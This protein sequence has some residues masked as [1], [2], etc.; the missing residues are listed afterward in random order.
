MP[1]PVREVFARGVAIGKATTPNAG[2]RRAATR[3]T[4]VTVRSLGQWLT[5]PQPSVLHGHLHGQFD[6]IARRCTP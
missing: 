2:S 1:L 3:R 4:K 6:G 5:G